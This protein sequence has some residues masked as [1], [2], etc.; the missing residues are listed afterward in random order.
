[1]EVPE[2]PKL[3][4]AAPRVLLARS[5][6]CYLQALSHLDTISLTSN[7]QTTT[8]RSCS[9]HEKH[10]LLSPQYVSVDDKIACCCLIALCLYLLNVE[11]FLGQLL[12]RI[13]SLSSLFLTFARR[14]HTPIE[15]TLVIFHKTFVTLLRS[16]FSYSLFIGFAWLRSLAVSPLETLI[17]L[18]VNLFGACNF[19]LTTR[20]LSFNFVLT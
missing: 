17:A 5:L 7:G 13:T 3:C 6:L 20:S 2:H 9:T 16:I 18:E 15:V 1:M 8:E 4:W 19:V 11:K 10:H 12:A 14:F